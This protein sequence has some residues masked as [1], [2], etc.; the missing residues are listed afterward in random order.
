MSSWRLVL[1]NLLIALVALT[2]SCGMYQPDDLHKTTRFLMGTFVELTVKGHKDKARQA[3]QAVFD[4]LKR[5]EDLTSFHKAS[6]LQK[7]NDSAG[8]GP[9]KSKPELVDLINTGLKFSAETHGAFDPTL[10]PL[11]S[12]WS[13]SA[14]EPRLPDK[15]DILR[16]LKKTGWKRIKVD[17]ANATISLPDKGMALDLGGIAKGY[18]LDRA[19]HVLKNLEVS[20]ALLNAGGDILAIGEKSPGR[21]WRVGVQD[22]RTPRGLAA[23]ATLSEKFIVTSGD[24]ERFFIKD[25]KR[26]HHILDPKTGYPT[27]RLQS[28]TIVA[29]T[30]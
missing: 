26:Y 8:T 5:V 11:T 14:G 23:I 4:E 17:E 6:E 24:Y 10:G 19:G 22:P 1:R 13:F 30:A 15:A 25:D 12:L 27:E 21:P 3:T 28:A 20:A 18:A 2:V 9:V 7:I 29:D 16:A